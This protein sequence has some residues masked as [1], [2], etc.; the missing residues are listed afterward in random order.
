MVR[1]LV[2]LHICFRK[3]Q[4]NHFRIVLYQYVKQCN[5]HQ[6]NYTNA[7]PIMVRYHH[8]TYLV[9][10]LF[11]PCLIHTYHTILYKDFLVPQ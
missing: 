3:F 2:W 5:T 10:C 6:L 4:P 8:H 1:K 7:H 9:H 11:R